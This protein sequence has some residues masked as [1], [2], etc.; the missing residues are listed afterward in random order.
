MSQH[1]MQDRGGFALAT[2]EVPS[3]ALA[4]A[5]IAG[6]GSD[7]D[8]GPYDV[9]AAAQRVDALVQLHHLVVD[10]QRRAREQ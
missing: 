1:N 6:R 7:L 8:V 2:L 4:G 9:I 5:V 3:D 10:G